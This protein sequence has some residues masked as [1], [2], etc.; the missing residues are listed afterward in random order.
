MS[1]LDDDHHNRVVVYLVEYSVDAGTDPVQVPTC[2]FPAIAGSWILSQALNPI[3]YPSNVVL[4]Y[5]TEILTN[6][7]QDSD[8]ILCHRLEAA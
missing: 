3:E 8:L 5:P 7:G 6:R 4:V 1:N 2:E